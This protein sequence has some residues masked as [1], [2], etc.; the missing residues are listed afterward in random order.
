MVQNADIIAQITTINLVSACQRTEA[1]DLC[2][3]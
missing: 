1:A 2:D 3:T